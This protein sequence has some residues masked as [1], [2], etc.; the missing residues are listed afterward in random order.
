MKPTLKL[1]SSHSATG[2]SKT[3]DLVTSLEPVPLLSKARG[4]TRESLVEGAK[5]KHTQ[6]SGGSRISP[7]RG[8]NSQGGRQHTKLPNFPKNCMKS[9]EFGPPGGG[10]RPSRPPLDPPMQREGLYDL[11]IRCE[12]SVKILQ[13]VVTQLTKKSRSEQS[14]WWLIKSHLASISPCAGSIFNTQGTSFSKNIGQLEKLKHFKI[15]VFLIFHVF[16]VQSNLSWV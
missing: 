5:Q 12:E 6:R 16:H 14:L 1:C 3:P 7:R 13:S 9:K 2:I 11:R 4:T 10:A 8:R 15:P